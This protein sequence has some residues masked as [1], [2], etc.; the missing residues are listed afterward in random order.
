M[1]VGKVAS[2]P[3]REQYVCIIADEMHIKADLVYD[4]HTGKHF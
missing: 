4:K 2:C 1:L 3:A